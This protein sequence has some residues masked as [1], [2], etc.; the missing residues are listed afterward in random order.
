MPLSV[1]Q[2]IRKAKR[3]AKAGDKAQAAALYQAVLSEFPNNARAIKGLTLLKAP[4]AAL[5]AK[6]AT[7]PTDVIRSLIEL[8]SKGRLEEVVDQAPVLVSQF[9]KSFELFNIL[10]I[11]H[12]RLSRF[13]EAATAFEKTV[14]LNP[15]LAEAHWNLGNAYKNSGAADKAAARFKKA[16]SLWPDN[17]GHGRSLGRRLSTWAVMM[18]QSRV[19]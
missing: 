2:S 6:G 13:A 18:R 11:T 8:S 9:P 14:A 4:A 10:G 19:S 16:A 15:N 12:S 1:D 7:P 3:C 17:A 5:A